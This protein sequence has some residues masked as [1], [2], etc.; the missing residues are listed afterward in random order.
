MADDLDMKPKPKKPIVMKK[1][2]AVG[3]MGKPSQEDEMVESMQEEWK[4]RKP[5]AV[6]K[7]VVKKIS[8]MAM[9]KP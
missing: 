9:K 1:V 7:P 5:G 8:V 6:G 3:E 2:V 4:G